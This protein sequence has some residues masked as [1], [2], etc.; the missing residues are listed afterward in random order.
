M[1]NNFIEL[2]EKCKDELK[3]LAFTHSSFANQ[4]G[5]ESNERV[6]FLGDTVLS[7]I[8]S[9]YL[10]KHYHKTEGKMTKIR[11]SFVCTENLSKL[12]KELGIESR[13]KIGKSLTQISDAI[14]ADTIESMIGVMYLSFGL[15]SISG[16]V[17]NALKVKEIL[18]AGG[19]KT[20]F[21]SELQEYTQER[22]LKLN[23][24]VEKYETAGGQMNFRANCFVSG[25]FLSYGQGSTKREAEQN[26]AK[27]ALQKL[28]KK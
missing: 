3:D 10:Y 13:I 2:F 24:E 11:S 28:K 4:H 16:A 25:E 5:V 19:I 17:L 27:L 23:Y 7:T 21:K 6:E 12:A 20:D 14:L 8:V 1:K 22:K 18:K 15:H 26:S 9:D